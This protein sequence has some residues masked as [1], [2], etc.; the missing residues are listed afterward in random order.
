MVLI[1]MYVLRA[2]WSSFMGYHGVNMGHR[3]AAGIHAE[4]ALK[5]SLWKWIDRPRWRIFL[6]FWP[7]HL[8]IHMAHMAHMSI[9]HNFKR[10][11]CFIHLASESV[12]ICV[13]RI[14]WHPTLGF[15]KMDLLREKKGTKCNY[16]RQR[17]T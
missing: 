5:K 2:P 6:N 11:H 17:A 12:M 1:R 14:C 9:K 4:R 8:W 7:W 16:Q 10:D 15:E 13:A 3:H